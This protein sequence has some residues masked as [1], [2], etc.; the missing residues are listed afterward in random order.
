MGEMVQ[1]IDPTKIPIV[2]ER[3]GSAFADSRDVAAFFGK[4]HED[5]LRAIRGLHCSHEFTTRNFAFRDEI[6]KHSTGASRTTFVEMTRSGFV[7]LVM[8]F[9][10]E[11]AA[12]FKERYINRFDSMERE[13][14]QRAATRVDPVVLLNDPAILRGLLGSYAERVEQLEHAV[15]VMAPKV[16]SFDRLVTAHG[17]VCIT[18]AAKQLQVPPSELFRWLR[19][20]NW[21]FKRG[22]ADVP[23]QS[24]IALG[25]LEAKMTTVQRSDGT[26]RIVVQ[27]RITAKGLA[28]LA[29]EFEGTPR[30]L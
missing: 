9:T 3:D 19:T 23:Y 12:E 14:Q 18:D 21:L 13:L 24:R 28:R 16:Q 17:S 27:A 8:G 25:Y 4:R 2:R 1:P 7:F 20:H 6:Q 10:G 29:G 5:V 26:D 30:L 22:G 15:G 11:R